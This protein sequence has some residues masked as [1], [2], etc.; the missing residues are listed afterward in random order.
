MGNGV[1]H[2]QIDLR[3]EIVC[4]RRIIYKERRRSSVSSY[5]SPRKEIQDAYMKSQVSTHSTLASF[6]RYAIYKEK[7]YLQNITQYSF[8]YTPPQVGA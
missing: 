3:N 7:I 4:K 2:D 5:Y 1:A 8:L 6:A